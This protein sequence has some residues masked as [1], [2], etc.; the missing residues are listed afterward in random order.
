MYNETAGM[1]NVSTTD[2]L[3]L[4][5]IGFWTHTR[6]CIHPSC[7]RDLL[8]TMIVKQYTFM[9]TLFCLSF[10]N[11]IPVLRMQFWFSFSKLTVALLTE[12]PLSQCHTCMRSRYKWI[13]LS[14]DLQWLFFPFCYISIGQ[15]P[16]FRC[17][18]HTARSVA[19]RFN[20]GWSPKCNL[21]AF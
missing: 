4:S 1:I 3:T 16:E 9:Q 10:W 14:I 21:F 15:I 8:W 2:P 7:C 19:Q 11:M 17:R 6:C 13:G 5:V 12:V 18:Y 20:T